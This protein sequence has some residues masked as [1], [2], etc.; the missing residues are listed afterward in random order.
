MDVKDATGFKRLPQGLL[1]SHF[2]ASNDG[3]TSFDVSQA[4]FRP[5]AMMVTGSGRFVM[6][7]FGILYMFAAFRPKVPDYALIGEIVLYSNGA[8]SS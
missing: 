3:L 7:L 4:L 6:P 8:L 2:L 1:L 5:C